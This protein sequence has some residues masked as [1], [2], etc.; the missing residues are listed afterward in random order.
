MPFTNVDPGAERPLTR[1]LHWVLESHGSPAATL[2]TWLVQEID[3]TA[4]TAL[5]ILSSPSTSLSTLRACKD[6]FKY[7]TIDGETP[8]DR[9]IGAVYYA[10]TIAS[11]IVHH[12]VRIS[13]QSSHA[14]EH[15][16][17]NIWSDELAD[18]KLRDLA[19]RAFVA[20]RL[21]IDRPS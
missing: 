20:L 12:R 1:A 3:P 15:A 8:D 5:D 4:E 16:F 18:L 6:A 10:A 2:A 19:W 14:L 13:R 7:L 11:G 9:A 17:R 21:G